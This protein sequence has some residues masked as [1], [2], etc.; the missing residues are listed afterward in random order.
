MRN[1]VLVADFESADEVLPGEYDADGEAIGEG[2]DLR[3]VPSAVAKFKEIM[4]SESGLLH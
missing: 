3:L 1:T 4:A 2:T